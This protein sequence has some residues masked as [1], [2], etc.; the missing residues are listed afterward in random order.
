MNIT[1][2]YSAVLALTALSTHAIAMDQLFLKNGDRFSGAIDTYTAGQ[3]IIQTSYGLFNV[4][5]D[6]IAGV[7]SDNEALQTDIVQMMS[8]SVA[9]APMAVNNSIINTTEIL[10]ETT[11]EVLDVT[12]D[13]T[14][15]TKQ[16]GLWG[17]VWTGK[18]T[19]DA[20]L[21]SGND[22]DKEFD[23]TANITARWD[24]RRANFKGDYNFEKDD[25]TKR[26]LGWSTR[27]AHDYFYAEKWFW[28]TQIGFERDDDDNLDLRSR[29]F[30]GP[31][32]QAYDRDDLS[33]AFTLG[34]GYEKEEF[35]NGLSN[36]GLATHFTTN[37]EQDVY[38]DI[39]IF[40]NNDLTVPFETAS[41][42]L[43]E[44][45][46]GVE[47]PIAGDIFARAGVDFDWDN[48]PALGVVE[49]DTE[50]FLSLGYEW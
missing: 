49:D 27:L 10:P 23:T 18:V 47:T 32:Y 5:L 6:Q 26:D 44:S 17:A 42:F 30:T 14:E 8:T 20:L 24:K 25:G 16:A 45:S 35:S 40:H 1:I 43:F 15:P 33:L 11:A 7:Q 3:V 36:N 2:F 46:T 31:G 50:Y 4:P 22:D 34:L 48:A 41:A 12:Q 29:F 9:P 38:E 13:T 39:K 19:V 37:Y 28:D 21:T